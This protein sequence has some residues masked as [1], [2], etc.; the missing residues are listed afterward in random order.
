MTS[1][2]ALLKRPSPM[3]V[4]T[5]IFWAVALGWFAY[6]LS[7]WLVEPV[8]KAHGF[9]EQW[10]EMSKD[11]FALFG[12][13]P[14]R[15]LAP[16]LAWLFGAG[17]DSYIA[18]T[19]VLHIVMLSSVFL[20][21]VR[22]RGL[23][24]DAFLVTCAVAI[25]APVQLYKQHWSGYTD[26]ICYT[27]F[28]WMIIVARN[29]YVFWLLFLTNLMNHELAGFLVPWLW[30]LRRRQDSRW[31][32]DLICMASAMAI[33]VAYYFWIKGSVEQ[34]Y[35]V[36][37]FLANPLFPGGTFVVWNLAAVHYTCTFGPLLAVLAWHQMTSKQV[38]E[39]WH[40]WL[41]TLGI[42]VIF[43]IAF[44]W[45]RHSNLMLL[46]L[47]IAATRF[48]GVGNGNRA[49]FVGLLLVSVVLFWMVPPWSPTAW[50]TNE[51]VDGSA[52]WCA[53]NPDKKFF[54]DTGIVV[55]T[56]AGIGFGPMSAAMGNWLPRVWQLLV[57]IHVIGLLFWCAGWLWARHENRLIR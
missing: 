22:L 11:P 34:T 36:D 39:R 27:L 38:G 12:Q 32:L 46:P 57:T 21:V 5:D 14:H 6:T 16:F 40:L 17:G 35:S 9:G 24:F 33:Y 44:D 2:D 19:H 29:P 54:L 8:P 41:V 20:V 31:R 42:L 55:P 52:E 30:F 26:P 53:A 25:T 50:P 48:L 1:A 49:L 4:G 7:C 47:V 23:Y 13:F 28:L 10:L 3:R 51:L 43:C 18:F 15:V 45:S 56:S 37:Y